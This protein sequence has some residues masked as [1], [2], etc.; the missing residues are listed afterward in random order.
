MTID[1]LPYLVRVIL[2]GSAI[3]GTSV[4]V[5]LAGVGWYL[6]TLYGLFAYDVPLYRRALAV[7]VVFLPLVVIAG[8]VA[9]RP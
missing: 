5:G 3:V 9:V 8:V 4:V 2:T 1:S 7:A 6:A